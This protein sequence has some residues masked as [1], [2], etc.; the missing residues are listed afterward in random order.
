L[1]LAG[2][3]K[4]VVG[5]ALSD[6]ISLGEDHARNIHLALAVAPIHCRDCLNY[7]MLFPV[8]RHVGRVSTIFRDRLEL[9][10]RIGQLVAE[11]CSAGQERIDL[12]ILGSADTQILA[13]C[14]HA[15]LTQAEKAFAHIHFTVLDICG[16]PL[17]LCRDYAARHNLA[18][19]TREIDITRTEE[20]FPA[21][22]IVL[23]SLLNHLPREAHLPLL[24]AC[25]RWLKPDGR[26]IFSTSIKTA[27]SRAR[28]RQRRD[29]ADDLIRRSIES[30][31]LKISEPVDAFLLRLKERPGQIC[32]FA[33]V[34]E[35]RDL[36]AG[37]DL[38]VLS[39]DEIRGPSQ[40]PSGLAFE[41]SRVLAVLG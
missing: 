15:V 6:P 8:Y 39:F 31:E 7:H 10:R 37:T 36:F 40:L 19:S 24:Q 38:A 35:V 14:A 29:Q 41:R 18:I 9:I 13:T 32:D 2:S 16:T 5:P 12:L 4:N 28:N 21:D 33:G 3:A 34:E 1:T 17:E 27:L 22:V 25:G 26:L 23:H 20:A 30:G 11:R